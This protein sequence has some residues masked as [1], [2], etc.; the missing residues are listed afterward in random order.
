MVRL[1]L[2][3]ETYRPKKENAFIEEKIISGGFLIDETPYHEASLRSCTNPILISEWAG[4]TECQIVAK[5]QDQV[6]EA[7][8]AT[9]SLW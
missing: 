7:L 3:L 6:K 2:D 8:V 1:Y 9:G 5:V 4:H